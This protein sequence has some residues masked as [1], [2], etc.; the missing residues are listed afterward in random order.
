AL[1]QAPE[2][3]RVWRDTRLKTQAVN[4]NDPAS[5][6]TALDG[7]N[8]DTA[9]YLGLPNGLWSQL[10]GPDQAGDGVVVGVLDTGIT[11]QHPSFADK[12]NVFIGPDFTAPPSTFKGIC[13][14]GSDP[15]FHCNS[16]LVGAHF[17]VDGFGAGNIAPDSF[18]S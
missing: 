8:G 2:V 11:P 17:F 6:E 12:G 16:K 15:T 13:D 1:R 9:A 14:T 7:P 10:G 18:L 4:P 5:V 3:A